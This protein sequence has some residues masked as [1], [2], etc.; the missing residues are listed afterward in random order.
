M[1][2][3]NPIKQWEI[4]F[5]Q[6]DFER[7]QFIDLFPPHEYAICAQEEHSNGGLHL[8][9]GL[10]LL[11]GLSHSKLIKYLSEKLPDDWKRIHVSPIKNWENWNDYCKK[12]DPHVLV[13]GSL[14]KRV[15]P[16]QRKVQEYLSEEQ[17]ESWENFKI[18]METER[19]E[20]YAAYL[21]HI[22]ELPAWKRKWQKEYD[23]LLQK[24][25]GDTKELAFQ[26]PWFIEAK[27]ED[28]ENFL[29]NVILS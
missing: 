20:N 24:C 19:I 12:E 17:P 22:N 28:F 3:R 4:T 13:K 2:N 21:F 27:K 6:T 1:K 16:L 11:K 25:N 9:L 29:N 14:A 18:R 23:L 7:E 5:P 26:L 10:K 8:H 15:S